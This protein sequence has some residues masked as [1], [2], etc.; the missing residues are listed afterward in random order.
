M[1]PVWLALQYLC[2]A[3]ALPFVPFCLAASVCA[4]R[5]D[6]GFIRRAPREES[7]RR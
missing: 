5:A 6:A 3:L 7:A 1:R 2:L 4:R